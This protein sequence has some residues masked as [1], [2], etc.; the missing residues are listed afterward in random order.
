MSGTITL[1]AITVASSLACMALCAFSSNAILSVFVMTG[2]VYL[3]M[4]SLLD[5]IMSMI[6]INKH[7]TF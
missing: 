3:V 2:L 6:I 1:Q 5:C 7:V 4:Y